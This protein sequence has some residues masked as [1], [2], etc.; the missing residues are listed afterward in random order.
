MRWSASRDQGLVMY[1]VMHVLAMRPSINGSKGGGAGWRG[2]VH[3]GIQS[4]SGFVT[5]NNDTA[6]TAPLSARTWTG[7]HIGPTAGW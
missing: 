4:Q 5:R 2:R 1:G 7:R 3:G 6:D